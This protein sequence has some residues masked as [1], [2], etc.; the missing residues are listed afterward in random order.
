[1]Q[2]EEQFFDENDILAQISVYVDGQIDDLMFACDWTD[3]EKSLSYVGEIFFQ[4]KYGNLLDK[5]LTQ[6]KS[7]C[8]EKDRQNDFEKILAH[9]QA[10]KLKLVKDDSIVVSPR[11]IPKL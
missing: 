7:Q 4:L 11:D 9:I 5:M 1:L 6:L 3:E 10:K 8:V 2:E